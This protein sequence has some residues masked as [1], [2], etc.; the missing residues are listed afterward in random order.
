MNARACN[1]CFEAR[2]TQGSDTI[3]MTAQEIADIRNKNDIENMSQCDSEKWY[4]VCE[5][6]HAK[7]NKE[8]IVCP[9]CHGIIQWGWLRS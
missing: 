1:S 5:L 6:C 8:D 9:C 4:M 2:E 7:I 3:N